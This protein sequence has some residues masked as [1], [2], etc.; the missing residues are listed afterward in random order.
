VLPF[1]EGTLPTLSQLFTGRRALG[2]AE[3]SPCT[4][5]LRISV[6][7]SEYLSR[8]TLRKTTHVNILTPDSKTRPIKSFS[9]EKP[10][11]K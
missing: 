4:P 5:E 8:D 10:F 9:K 2:S 6:Q 7:V 3:L 1:P 11:S